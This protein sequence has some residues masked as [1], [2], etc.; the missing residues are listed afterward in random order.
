MIVP[1]RAGTSLLIAAA[2]MVMLAVLLAPRVSQPAGYHHFADQR[3][4]LG[5]PRFG[6]VTSNLPFAVIG[7]WG[8]AF[9]AGRGAARAFTDP[10]ERCPYFLALFGLVLTA[11]GVHLLPSSARQRPACVGS[12]A[13]DRSSYGP[14]RSD[15][16]GARQRRVRALAS[17][18]TTRTGRCQ[19]AAMV[20]ERTPQRG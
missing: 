17:P 3:E 16:R 7:L 14:S 5:V 6:D 20:L 15:D 2:L 1:A 8:L 11:F 18:A 10:R 4:W 12:A 9:L 19:R 13:D